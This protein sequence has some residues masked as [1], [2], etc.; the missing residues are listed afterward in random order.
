MYKQI[1][2]YTVTSQQQQQQLV[3]QKNKDLLRKAKLEASKELE[4]ARIKMQKER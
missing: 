4:A 2:Y 3:A 1:N